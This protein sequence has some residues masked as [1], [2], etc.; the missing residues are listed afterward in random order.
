MISEIVTRLEEKTASFKAIRPAEDV[1]ALSKGTAPQDA[2][3]F[4]LPYRERATPS[5]LMGVYRQI[6]AVQFLVAFFV[7]RHDD[8]QGG[9][10]IGVFDIMKSEIEAALAGWEPD[11]LATPV[12]LVAGQSASLGNGATVYVQTWETS[13][14]LEGADP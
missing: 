4:V 14:Y 8:A 11:F 6:V 2:T 9:K 7:R 1:D 12:E 13:R 10:K 3:V 5:E